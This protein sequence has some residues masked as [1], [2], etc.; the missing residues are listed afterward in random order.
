MIS[1]DNIDNLKTADKYE[2]DKQIAK[3]KEILQSPGKSKK[4]KFIKTTEAKNELNSE[5]INKTNTLLGIKGYHTNL[6]EKTFSNEH[7]TERYHQ[8]YKI[9]QAYRISKHDL[10]TRPIFHFKED[11]IRLHVLICFMALS[12]PKYIEIETNM[13]IHAFLF[14]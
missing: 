4:V 9:E 14:M 13:S 1:T 5:L 3:A 12:V 6:D 8:L 2:M 11:P 10:K 7:V